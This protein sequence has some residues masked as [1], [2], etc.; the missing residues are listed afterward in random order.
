MKTDTISF[1][2]IVRGNP[3]H[4]E[5]TATD[6]EC[7]IYSLRLSAWMD[8]ADVTGLLTDDDVTTLESEALQAFSARH[9]DDIAMKGY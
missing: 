2:S 3:L 6:D 7:G 4:I 9:A 8:G 1:D 5:A